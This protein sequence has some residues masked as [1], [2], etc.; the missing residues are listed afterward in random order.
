MA[1]LMTPPYQYFSD[2]N[3]NPLSGGKI[4][5]YVAGSVNTPK[6]AYTTA[7]G[8]I[9][10]SNPIILDSAGRAVIFIEGSYKYTITDSNDVVIRTVDNVTSFTAF[11]QT[12]EGFFQSFSGNASQTAFTLSENLG[13]D[14]KSIL[15][16]VNAGLQQCATNGTFATDTGWTKGA[17]WTIGAGV[18]T[19]TGAIS[20]AISQTAGVTLVAGQAY[21]VTMTITRS[22]GGLAPSVGGT[23][24]TS[25]TASGTYS[26]TII[27][28]S[29]G[30]IAFTGA[31]FT[32]T[33]DN[34]TVT[35]AVSAGY[36]V[37]S[38]AAF[39][40]SSTT[41]T[42]AVAPP[43]GTNNIYVY[44]PFQ[45]AGAAG[46]A[47]VAADAAAA[48]AVSAAAD[49]AQTALDRIATAA[50]RVQT[51]LDVT[52]ANTSA[53][54]AQNYSQSYSGTSTTSLLIATGA[55]VFTTQ[56]GKLWVAGQQLQIASNANNAN[57]MHGAVTTY[58]GTTLTMSITDIG[59]SGTLADWNIS[60]SGTRGST[61]AAVSDGDKGD[62]TVASSG[63]VWTI[64]ATAVTAAKMS[65]GAATNGQVATANGSGAVTYASLPAATTSASGIVELAT[66][67]EV[68]T[69]TDTARTPSV[70][71]MVAHQG[72]AKAWVTFDASSGTPVI[73]DSYNVSSITDNGV[74]DFT[75]NFTTAFTNTSYSWALSGRPINAGESYGGYLERTS[76]PAVGSFRL[77]TSRV[78][79]TVVQADHTY[80]T[81]I[82]WG[83]Q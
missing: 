23:A 78:G 1:V 36:Q 30:Q 31:G 44:A 37:Q 20:T 48:S 10:L 16:F 2:D 79:G 21:I 38:P 32:G 8:D 65:S 50:D 52:S 76:T 61:G 25:R 71:T 4:Y 72:I 29:D 14:E 45:L 34:V 11:T 33:L 63:T 58:S 62:I 54:N 55:K 57:Y 64:D 39:T 82:F 3:G 9:E 40:L 59:G 12:T 77:I 73:L 18:A 46:A 70:S 74:G 22:A 26:E 6:A 7:E 49:A 68:A 67:A 53:T 81:A 28:G 80:N 69:G 41:L 56:S 43:V 47:Q 17:G 5:T 75:I 13:D 35:P 66:A 51:G 60:I 27:A 24:G 83:D 15:V 19:A 42:F